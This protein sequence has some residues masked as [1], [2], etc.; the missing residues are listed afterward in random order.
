MGGGATG[1][2]RL[3]EVS[4]LGQPAHALSH[5]P[6]FAPALPTRDAIS[7]HFLHEDCPL[8]QPTWLPP[9]LDVSQLAIVTFSDRC[10]GRET[11]SFQRAEMF[12]VC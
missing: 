1:A 9:R 12:Y 5:L 3:W 6:A 10:P 2:T 4:P 7:P 8:L 11:A